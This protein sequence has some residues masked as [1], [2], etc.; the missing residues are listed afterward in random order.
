MR[1]YKEFTFDAA[2]FL[3]GAP[4]GHRNRRV[5]GH[6]FKA[7]IWL[8]GPVDKTSGLVR[9]FEV[10][11]SEIEAFH[12]ELDHRMLNEIEGLENPTLELITM[13]LWDRMKP[14]LPELV[15]IELHRSSCNEGC[16]YD[17]PGDK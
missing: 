11:K 17:G 15:R 10:F 13:W 4:E 1:I 14:T 7:V 16:I 5:H 12:V 3:P 9:N 8:E 2:H 6:S